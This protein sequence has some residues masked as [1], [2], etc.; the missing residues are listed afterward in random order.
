M[1]KEIAQPRH[2]SENSARSVDKAV[3]ELLVHAEKQAM[4][5]IVSHRKQ[6]DNLINELEEHEAGSRLRFV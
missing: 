1:G 6:L 2:F 3:K 4:D 5:L